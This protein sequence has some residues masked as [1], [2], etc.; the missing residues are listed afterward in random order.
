[1]FC[2]KTE[3]TR[4]YIRCN[5]ILV[6]LILPLISASYSLAQSN[7][8]NQDELDLTPEEISWLSHHKVIRVAVDPTIRPI[9]FID[10]DG[11]ISGIAGSYLKEISQKLNVE[12][13]WSGG[14]SLEMNF[15]QI[16]S[17]EAHMIS[18]LVNTE[19]RRKSF[20][21]TSPY[22]SITQVVF[23]LKGNDQYSDL[24]K[25]S[26][27]KVSQIKGFALINRIKNDFPEIEIIEV[28]SLEKALKSISTGEADAYV[29]DILSTLE[30]IAADG[31][32]QLDIVGETPYK[33][34]LAMA[35][36]K[37]FPLLASSLNKALASLKP[38]E[39]LKI[40]REWLAIN[41][42]SKTDYELFIK[43][44]GAIIVLTILIVIW[45]II[46]RKEVARRIS[47]EKQLLREREKENSLKHDEKERERKGLLNI[48][49]NSPVGASVTR[50]EDGIVLYCNNKMA[51][52]LETKSKDIIGKVE[53]LSLKNR[54]DIN[55]I[56]DKEGSVHD[57]EISI[58]R[59]SGKDIEV[60]CSSSPI[61]FDGIEA[62]L[63]WLIDVSSHKKIQRNLELSMITAEEAN[64][65]KSIF[66]A[67]MSHEIR[68]P[69]N[70]IIG[71]IDLLT[72][73]PLNQEQQQM[74]NTTK[75]SAYALLRIIDDIL[76]FS[77]VEA[78][79]LEIEATKC[80]LQKIVEDVGETLSGS[81]NIKSLE[82]NTYIDP[83]IP[84]NILSDGLRISQILLNLAGNAIKFTETTD[85]Q[86]GTIDIQAILKMIDTEPDNIATVQLSVSDNG[87]GIAKEQIKNLFKPF[88]QLEASTTRRFGG[89]G[90]G[91]AIC[92][93]L[94][95]LLK[96]KFSV[97]SEEGKGTKFILD[98]PL[99]F[100][101]GNALEDNLLPLK[102]LKCLIIQNNTLFS[103]TVEEYLVSSGC[104]IE[105]TS[106]LENILE[107]VKEAQTAVKPYDFIIVEPAD[108]LNDIYQTLIQCSEDVN[109]D[110][111]RSVVIQ[112][113]SEW[114]QRMEN[115]V[116]K[117]I[118][119]NPMRHN[120]LIWTA[121]QAAKKVRTPN[122][123]TNTT[124]ETLPPKVEKVSRD[125]ERDA[126]RLILVAEDN[127]TN[128]VVLKM[129]L[130][131]LGYA[132]DIVDNG[133]EALKA[134]EKESYNLILTDCH[135]PLLD[136]Y[137]LAEN[138]RKS[139]EST[140][141]RIPIIAITANALKLE[142]ERC[143]S[144]G[145][146]HVIHKPVNINDLY[147]V[148]NHWLPK[149]NEKKVAN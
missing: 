56:L 32:G 123:E 27:K 30:V 122:I 144:K 35:I 17:G 10:Q 109:W 60:M 117:F 96:G 26:G 100:E 128:Q 28:A 16:K 20:N 58:P 42:E 70:G 49:A 8:Q 141:Q 73:T 24:T 90:L 50:I 101:A 140:N 139:E 39:R 148:L 72:E 62:R 80:N 5:K 43:I 22:T 129:Q 142:T 53:F 25:L 75:N 124:N 44:I 33:A 119:G 82:L 132:F 63:T 46:L 31:L 23:S 136:G 107:K 61:M 147:K 127:V 102:D 51:E 29:G 79:K 104:T 71:I 12:F 76:E 21:F 111:Q 97:E 85:E 4:L 114:S 86:V 67:T 103:K 91:L 14:Q 41:V 105:A 65:S 77:K 125:D 120:D 84:E 38:E 54:K 112:N 98:L 149:D 87:I 89:T 130:T 146:D 81:A 113:R 3:R 1:M 83:K 115:T 7:S 40:S 135:M 143:I 15:E 99:K 64:N 59:K 110:L 93:S 2:R 108:N 121:A 95:E 137:G 116:L 55:N 126:G 9:E 19:E 106:E 68:T 118:K 92:S 57:K 145:M 138:I 134:L 66:L 45:N 48:F 6:L 88:H 34:D 37:D 74:I 131:R 13:V 133:H 94:A 18:A 36:R 52:M 69:M 11:N 47:V 78:G